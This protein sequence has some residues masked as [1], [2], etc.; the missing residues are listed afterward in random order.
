MERL[1]ERIA[2]TKNWVLDKLVENVEKA[3]TVKS[4]S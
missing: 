2:L 4:G 3:M 1:G